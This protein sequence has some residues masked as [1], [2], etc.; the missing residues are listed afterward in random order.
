MSYRILLLGAD[1]KNR[2]RLQQ[3]LAEEISVKATG[4][5]ME[6]ISL[7][8]N[9]MSDLVLLDAT[10]QSLDGFE[11]LRLIRSRCDV[12]IIMLTESGPSDRITAL[13]MGADD[14]VS[15]NCHFQELVARVEAILR[16]YTPAT[17]ASRPIEIGTVRIDPGSRNAWVRGAPLA[18]TSAEYIILETLMR[19]AGRVVTRERLSW[20][21]RQRESS[22]LDRSLDV[23]VAHLRNKLGRPSSIRT[24]RGE[25]YFFCYEPL[26]Q[27]DEA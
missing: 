6:G 10:S 11:L 5:P 2:A 8:C 27:K 16:R 18:L 4:D 23:H 1:T 15:F 13:Q 24:V 3:F 26:E 19:M 20:T 25:G 9:G 22:G 21:L 14:C 7:A 12:P 17:S